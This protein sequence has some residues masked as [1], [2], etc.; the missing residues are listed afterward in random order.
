MGSHTLHYIQFW[1][2]CPLTTN[3][4]GETNGNKSTWCLA[5]SLNVTPYLEAFP[6]EL[7]PQ[8]QRLIICRGLRSSTTSQLLF[9]LQLT[10]PQLPALLG[11]VK[12]PRDSAGGGVFV[13]VWCRERAR[14]CACLERER[15]REREL[16]RAVTFR[17][18][19]GF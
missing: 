9:C 14:E 16:Q 8:T 6:I 1:Y 4:L 10:S 2:P 19:L 7:P 3:N 18:F 13:N 5:F 12:I 11:V 17:A 15:E